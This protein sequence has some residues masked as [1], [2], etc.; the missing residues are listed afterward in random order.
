MRTDLFSFGDLLYG[1]PP[2]FCRSGAKPAP[3]S[4]I[5][6]RFA[7]VVRLNPAIR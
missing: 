4:A 6:H 7:A 5:L 3:S 2:E 1:W